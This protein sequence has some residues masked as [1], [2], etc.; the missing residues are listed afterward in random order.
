[1]LLFVVRH[2]DPIYNPDS[3][4]PKGHLQAQALAKRFAVN[5]LDEIYA[6]PLKRAQQ[7]AQPTCDILGK[8]FTVEEWTSENKAAADLFCTHPDGRRGWVFQR[9]LSEMKNDNTVSLNLTNWFTAEC[10]SPEDRSRFQKGYERIGNDSDVFL[11]KLGYRREGAVYKILNPN[12]KRVAVFCHQGFGVTWLSHLLQI[13]PHIFWSSFD[14]AH[15]SVTVLEFKNYKN[16]ITTPKCLCLSDTSHIL[17][18]G[19]PFEYNNS[20][21]L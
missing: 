9:Q 2:G 15:S 5:G 20:I 3:L 12:E 10:F 8:T 16:G 11:E 19:L 21:K 7:T 13:P 18:E 1:M 14:L 4:T 6:S 17:R